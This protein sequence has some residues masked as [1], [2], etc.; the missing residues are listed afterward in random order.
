MTILSREESQERSRLLILVIIEKQIKKIKKYIKY[1]YNTSEEDIEYIKKNILRIRRQF[2]LFNQRI[3]NGTSVK[4]K[5]K[6]IEKD[7]HYIKKIIKI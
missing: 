6:K 1:N 3:D 4:K 2:E 7:I 5:L